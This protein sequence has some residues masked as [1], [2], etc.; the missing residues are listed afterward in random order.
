MKQYTNITDKLLNNCFLIYFL[1][2]I[3][4]KNINNTANMIPDSLENNDRDNNITIKKL[5]LFLILRA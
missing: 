3:I 4:S 1:L 5:L 2:N